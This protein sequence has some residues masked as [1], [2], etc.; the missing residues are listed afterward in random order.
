MVTIDSQYRIIAS[1]KF[2][3]HNAC[4]SDILPLNSDVCVTCS[5]DTTIRF[6]NCLTGACIKTLQEYGSNTMPAL[7]LGPTG[8]E[9]ACATLDKAV[10]IWS[11]ETFEILRRIESP[12]SVRSLV[13]DSDTL[14]VGVRRH[15][16]MSCNILTGEVGSIIFRCKGNI[17]H[18]ALGTMCVRARF[19]HTLNPAY[20]TV[21][22]RQAWAPSTHALWSSSAQHNVHTAV[23]V[24]WKARTQERR[25]QVPY[26]LVEAILKHV[27]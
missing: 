3:G 4:V 1:V 17:T 13:A 9:F 26:E 25:M 8:R 5:L 27:V 2:T 14:Y 12:G 11:S 22:S 23:A 15:G 20:T 21:S 10:I 6:W 24:L 7:V 19:L 18:L 16:I